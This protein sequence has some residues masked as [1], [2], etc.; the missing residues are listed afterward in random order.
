M[1]TE[2]LVVAKF[3]GQYL[4]IIFKAFVIKELGSFVYIATYLS[5]I[6][7]S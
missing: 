5:L 6:V 1:A 4:L 7:V 2:T 3:M